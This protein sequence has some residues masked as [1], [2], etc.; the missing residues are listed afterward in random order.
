MTAGPESGELILAGEREPID[1]ERLNRRVRRI[2]ELRDQVARIKEWT[3]ARVRSL[4]QS[5]EWEVSQVEVEAMLF[6]GET[7]Q[8]EVPLTAGTVSVRKA[9]PRTTID[10]KELIAW[11]E[12]PERS[13]LR[14]LYAKERRD[15]RTADMMPKKGQERPFKWSTPDEE[16]ISELIYLGTGE[17][18]PG[19]VKYHPP[20][21]DWR[22]SI[23]PGEIVPVG[24]DEPES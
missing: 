20:D 19:C 4:E 8:V 3:K 14:E 15:W 9:P 22:V 12:D 16:G 13:S 17:V 18:V 24:D 11:L 6:R 23:K 1:L 10:E 5:I 7:G 21:T 2:G